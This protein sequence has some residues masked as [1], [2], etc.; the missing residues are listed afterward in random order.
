MEDAE[1]ETYFSEKY[2]ATGRFRGGAEVVLLGPDGVV[3]RKAFGKARP[4]S[5][6][7]GYSLTKIICSIAV[8]QQALMPVRVMCVCLCACVCACARA[9]GGEFA[10]HAVCA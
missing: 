4:N 2:I 7:P 1:F 6:Y 8:M 3:F 9:C 10:C 5:L